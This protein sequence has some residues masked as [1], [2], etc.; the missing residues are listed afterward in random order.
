MDELIEEV[1]AAPDRESLVARSRALDRVL[2]WGH[3]LVPHWH[4]RTFRLAYWNMFSRPKV[5]PKY[6]LGFDFWWID[7]EKKALLQRGKGAAVSADLK[8]EEEEE[9]GFTAWGLWLFIVAIAIFAF[10]LQRLLQR[11]RNTTNDD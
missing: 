2:L 4:I 11:R 5:T 10:L 7:P 9:P 6:A 3:Y 1:I 8:Q